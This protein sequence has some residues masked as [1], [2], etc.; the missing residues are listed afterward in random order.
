MS[1]IP[2]VLVDIDQKLYEGLLIDSDSYIVFLIDEYMRNKESY[3]KEDI[4]EIDPELD[5]DDKI[6]SKKR[7]DNYSVKISIDNNNYNVIFSSNLRDIIVNLENGEIV[8][9]IYVKG[10]NIV[11]INY[12][13]VDDNV[14]IILMILLY[15]KRALD[16]FLVH[17]IKRRL[18][19]GSVI[20]K[21]LSYLSDNDDFDYWFNDRNLYWEFFKVMEGIDGRR[22]YNK[23]Y[24][25]DE[26][27]LYLN[28]IKYNCENIQE[29]TNKNGLLTYEEIKSISNYLCNLS[30]E[31]LMS[32]I[33][34][35]H[36]K[37][38]QDEDS[39]VEIFNYKNKINLLHKVSNEDDRYDEYNTLKYQIF[40]ELYAGYKINELRKD[41]PNFMCT[42]TFF[43]DVGPNI[44]Y[45]IPHIISEYIDNSITMQKSFGL[46]DEKDFLEKYLII[47]LSLRF[48]YIKLKFTHY[49]LHGDNV[50]IKKL[51]LPI[52]LSYS[53]N[54]R[55]IKFNTDR[56]PIIIDYG[57]SCIEGV[58]QTS[59]FL[60]EY[61]I[62][63]ETNLFHDFHKLFYIL[64][65]RNPEGVNKKRRTLE[66]IHDFF[67]K[68]ITLDE[69]LKDESLA[70]FYFGIPKYP[71]MD[72]LDMVDSFIE[73]LLEIY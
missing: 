56:I 1:T 29:I 34:N 12:E 49:D 17:M 24:V 66:H 20:P 52:P 60:R 9:D 53:F 22:K 58:E 65:L 10:G 27:Q 6:I 45:K 14:D 46:Y 48:A 32:Y 11:H 63:W 44:D 72:H 38:L 39:L 4:I 41:I 31:E 2:L 40:S 36:I 37:K 54:D 62:N 23:L 59:G 51:D 61:F 25:S 47:C 15:K 7:R 8:I 69:Y 33:N 43:Y 16:K 73:H 50:L 64:M 55:M 70:F 68:E 28:N 19:K 18:I 71:R 5:I 21:M 13:H 57:S 26:K 3:E 42:F 35:N 30:S 67:H